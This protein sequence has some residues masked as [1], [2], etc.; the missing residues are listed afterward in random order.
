MK[1]F[2]G[3]GLIASLVLGACSMAPIEKTATVASDAAR[4]VTGA[5]G[6]IE[7]TG[8]S[9]TSMTVTWNAGTQVSYAK[10]FVSEGNGAGLVLA[11]QDMN[12]SAGKYTYTLSHPTFTSGAK[13]YIAVLKNQG[14]VEACVPQG[15]LSDTTSWARITYGDASAGSTTTTTTDS[16]ALVAG[17]VYKLVAKCS[18][19]ALDVSEVSKTAGAN[20][21]Q[22][23]YVGG[24]NQK[25]KL[26]ASNESG[27]YYLVSVNSGMALD[28]AG[29]GTSDGT[30]LIQWTLGNGQANQ[31]WK[32]ESNGDGTYKLTNKYAN[33]V[34]DVSGSSTENGGNVQLWTWNSS[35]AQRWTLTRLDSTSTDT[36]TGTGTTTGGDTLIGLTSGMEMTIQFKN[37]TRGTYSNDRI[38]VCVVGQNSAGKFCYLKPDGTLVPIVADQ[39]SS[40]WSY[41]LSDISGF[42]VPQTMPATR[43][44]VSMDGPVVMRGIVDGAGNI[45]VVQPDLNNPADANATLIFDW[46]EYTV[47]PGAF[48]GNTT[49]VDQFGFPI[50]MEMYNDSGSSY[51][52]F[53]KVGIQETRE[54]IFSAFENIAQT[55]FR[56]LVQ[57][58]YR[59]VA[60][61]KGDFRVGRTYGTY[62]SSY[63]DQVWNYYKTNTLSFDHPLG[64][65]NGKV[66]SDN[67]FEFTRASDGAKFY[68]SG[69]PNNDELFEG[70]GVLATGNSVELALQAQMCAALNRHIVQSPGSWSTPS[71][72]YPAG[73]ANYYAKFWHDHNIDGKAYGF[74]YDDVADQSTL[75]ES[76]APRGL[77]IGIGW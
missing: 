38:W 52:S 69:K 75:I 23:D 20:V 16:S 14:G 67:R 43:L 50:T 19:K 27:Y 33:K 60:P 51:A 12:Y 25:W 40:A 24:E 64:Y 42:Q 37:N 18:G 26:V 53:K 70:S 71:A 31:K 32:I 41:R 36:G 9:G 2:L 21:H 54:E 48:W 46:V 74:C 47:A 3:L 17:G 35:N 8:M 34:L 62:M 13:I 10:L 72:Y 30:N 28:G 58:P 61:C 76:H 77:V 56:G 73:P 44:Y 65:F 63:V 55:E 5:N 68:I 45:G 7:V 22:W 6:T 29:W 66:L 11:S 1:R 39:T 59:I 15:T 49:Q 4:A 57:R